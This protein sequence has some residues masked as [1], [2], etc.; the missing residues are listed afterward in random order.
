MTRPHNPFR[1]TGDASA[2]AADIR[3]TF[4]FAGDLAA[5]YAGLTA[6]QAHKWHHYLPLYDRYFARF[7]GTPVRM[8]EIGC[9]RGGSLD[10]WRQYLGPQAVLFGID[11]DPHCKPLDGISAQVRIGSQDDP[12]FL[13]EV[14]AEMGGVDV[15]LDDGSHVMKHVRASL[16][17][18]FPML[19]TGGLYMIEDMHTAWLPGFGGGQ[20][21]SENVFL[22][23]L[24]EIYADMHHWWHPGK[25]RHPGLGAS[26]SAVQVH[27]GMIVL[28]KNPVARPVNSIAGGTP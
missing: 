22:G 4:G 24:P 27:P 15:V 8:L 18:L 9:W 26:V 13:A 14:V 2:I 7:R 1:F 23:L 11:I 21:T 12:L 16:R 5:I 10:M 20:D 6:R 25:P 28:E 19:E 3:E 17:T